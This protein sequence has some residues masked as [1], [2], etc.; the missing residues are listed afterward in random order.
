MENATIYRCT[1]ELVRFVS[2]GIQDVIK[3]FIINGTGMGLRHYLN[4]YVQFK[5]NIQRKQLIFDFF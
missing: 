3:F 5:D 2:D 4:T 1:C